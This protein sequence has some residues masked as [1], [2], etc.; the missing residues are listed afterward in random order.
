M[1]KLDRLV[2]A[3]GSSILSYGTRIG[4]RVSEEHALPD[5]LQRLPPGWKLS[6]S[7]VVDRMYSVVVGGPGDR[8]GVRRLNLV[9][10]NSARLWRGK[11]LD[12]ALT[13]VERD[14]ELYVA[15]TA[16][17]RVFVH[18]GVV[19]WR[20][21]AI[22][23]PRPTFTG[24]TT[25]TAALVRAGAVYY[26]DEYAVLDRHGRVHPYARPLGVRH[27]GARSPASRE[28]AG[29]LGGVVGTKPLPI[30]LVLLTTY[31][32]GKRFRPRRLSP[33]RGVLELLAHTISARRQPELL[34]ET[35]AHAVSGVLVLKG[36][37][38]EAEE[39][40]ASILDRLAA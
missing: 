16:R 2:W 20:G 23:L 27:D 4:I 5:L 36:R 7:P 28:D 17:R 39:T 26:S 31:G 29:S 35:L 37:R 12:N 32:E 33:G 10:A 21:R 19:G 34:L 14:V 8:P 15:E 40:T 30:A 6:S 3:A 11:E 24:K 9:Y 38:G 18:A 25:L 22:V 13:M 1:E